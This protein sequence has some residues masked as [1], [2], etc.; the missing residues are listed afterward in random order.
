MGPHMTSP[1]QEATNVNTAAADVELP[2]PEKKKMCFG[3]GQPSSGAVSRV[4]D[5]SKRVGDCTTVC[6][7]LANIVAMIGGVPFNPTS[8]DYIYSTLNFSSVFLAVLLSPC[9][10]WSNA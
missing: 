6:G 4:G 10:A 7:D 2:R 9:L 5:S 8:G 1:G 3:V